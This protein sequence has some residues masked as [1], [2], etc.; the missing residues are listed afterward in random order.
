MTSSEVK[1]F[2]IL[3]QHNSILLQLTDTMAVSHLH[4][5]S[6]IIALFLASG[7]TS[8]DGL[9]TLVE[10]DGSTDSSSL[11]LGLLPVV[12]GDF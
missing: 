12:L 6:L 4:S 7:I 2:Y 11:V 5:S 3:P 8:A 9:D 10:E 1:C